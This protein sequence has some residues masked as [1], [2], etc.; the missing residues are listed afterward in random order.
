ME[1]TLGQLRAIELPPRR[2]NEDA[3]LASLR[4]TLDAYAGVSDDTRLEVSEN[5]ATV[6]DMS[7]EQ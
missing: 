3:E 6:A 5:V 1:R 7:A 4:A 2:E